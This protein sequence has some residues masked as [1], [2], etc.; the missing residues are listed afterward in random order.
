M[1]N[2]DIQNL[3]AKTGI[4]QQLDNRNTSEH[5]D[6]LA[7]PF[8]CFERALGRALDDSLTELKRVIDECLN[9]GRQPQAKLFASQ[10]PL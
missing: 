8:T 9:M 6:K 5:W 4:Y 1:A 7:K 3:A 10:S 2:G